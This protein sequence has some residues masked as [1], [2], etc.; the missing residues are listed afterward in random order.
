MLK[1]AIRSQAQAFLS[2]RKK[3]CLVLLCAIQI[4]CAQSF[5]ISGKISDNTTRKPIKAAQITLLAADGVS[6]KAAIA[7]N[8]DGKFALNGL[9][10]SSYLLRI[11]CVGYKPMTLTI[12]ELNKDTDLGELLLKPDT[13]QLDEVMVSANLQKKA[14]RWVFYPSDAIKRQSTDAYDVLQRMALPDLQ[15]DL[16]NRTLSSQKGGALQIRINGVP[17]NHSDLAALQPQDIARVEYIDNPGIVYGDGVAAVLLVHTKRGYEGMQ[18][19]VQIANALT[20]KQGNAYAYFKLIGLKNQLSIK[21]TSHYKN[22]GGVFTNSNKTFR[23]P[24]SDMTLNAQGDDR[25][26]RLRGG[27]IQLEYNRLLDERNSFFNVMANYTTSYRPE[28]VSASR[29]QHN[30]AP[31]FYEELLTKDKTHNVSLDLYLDKQFASKANLLANLTVTY[32]GSD[33]HRAYNKVYHAAAQPAFTNAYDVDGQ[34]KSIIGEIVFKQPLSKRH[35]LSLGTYNRLSDTRNTYEATNGTSPTS[36][37]NFNNYDYIE[38][39]GTLGKLNYS[40]GGGYSFYRTKNDSLMAN[41]HFFR[42]SLTLSYSLS[43]AFRLQYYLGI[44][45]VEPQLAMLSSFVQTQSEYELRKGNPHLKPYQAYINQLSL[46]FRKHETTASISTY[47]QYSRHPF[48]NNPPTYDAAANMFVYTLA[49]QHSFTHF[50]VRLNASQSLFSQ[51]FKLFGWL[52]L[53]RYINNGLSFFTTYTDII[54]GLSLTYDHTKWGM[55]ANFCSAITTMFNETKTR[56]APTLQLS[57]YYNIHRLRFTLSV[58]N[59]F[60]SVATTVSTLNSEL[61]SSTSHVF[62]K[63]NDNLVQL[64]LS[65]HFRKGKARNLQ[66]QMDNAD[67]DAGVVK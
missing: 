37:F 9:S 35:N 20:A 51:A 3:L 6:A 61:V 36:L 44:N 34:H 18:G 38:L 25:T 65:Y 12:A 43:K 46:S 60:M 64:S 56:T 33:Y 48:T 62:Q 42:P 26:Y 39:S 11:T 66:K 5:F 57:A 53:N 13:V 14:D 29:I 50:Q 45:P 55:Q 58:N 31:F 41:Y 15:F 17:S 40:V 21:A 32:I 10:P 16:M 47:I 2:L 23:Y 1:N 59:P 67:N 22:V 27:S 24:T 63:Y 30:D 19:G 8:E 54:G 7:S 49:N 4:V 52:T 28:N